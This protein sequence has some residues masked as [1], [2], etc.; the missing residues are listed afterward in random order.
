MSQER[1]LNQDQAITYAQHLGFTNAGLTLGLLNR[2]TDCHVSGDRQLA[3]RYMSSLLFTLAGIAVLVMSAWTVCSWTIPWA[4]VLKASTAVSH[5]EIKDAVLI[6][7]I[8]GLLGMVFNLP[9]VVYSAYQELTIAN[10]WDAASKLSVL[11]AT[12]VVARTQ[13]GLFGAAVATCC[14]PTAISLAN[15]FWIFWRR[16]WLRPAIALFDRRLVWSTLSD[17]MLL[18]LFA[19]VGGTLV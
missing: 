18:S 1:A 5:D 13:W 8:A 16:P 7:G 2:L 3:R 19:T 10:F 14:V 11:A 17:G 9:T 15:M 6:A 4:K 12:F